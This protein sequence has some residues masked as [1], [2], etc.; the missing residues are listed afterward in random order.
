MTHP[1]QEWIDRLIE[2]ARTETPLALRDEPLPAEALREFFWLEDPPRSMVITHTRIIGDLDLT[3]VAYAHPLQLDSC[4]IEGSVIL[5]AATF[6]GISLT[7]THLRGLSFGGAKIDGDARFAGLEATGPVEGIGAHISGDLYLT[8]ATLASNDA[9]MAALCLDGATI[10]GAFQAPNL[11]TDGEFRAVGIRIRGQLVLS[12][13]QLQNAGGTALGLDGAEIDFGLFANDRFR[14]TGLVRAVGARIGRWVSFDE[15]NVVNDGDDALLLDRSTIAGAL[16][17]NGATLT[18]PG[19]DALSIQNAEINGGINLAEGFK[20]VGEIRASGIHIRGPLN[21]QG[22]TLNNPGAVA[23]ALEGAVITLGIFGREGFTVIGQIEAPALQVNGQIDLT[24]GT[25]TNPDGYA[26]RLDGAKIEGDFFARGGFSAVGEV[27]AEGIRVSGRVIFA[28][29]TLTNRG[30]AV[31]LNSAQIQ[32]L[33]VGPLSFNGM[34]D[35]TRCAL[36]ELEVIADPPGPLIA[37]GWKL[38]DLRGPLHNNWRAADRWLATAPPAVESV[39]PWHALADVYE[40]NGNPHGGRKLRFMAANRLTSQ[41]PPLSKAYG[42]IYRILVGHGYYPLQAA[43]WLALILIATAV[44]IASNRD[45][46]VP[47]NLTEYTAA[48]QEH[49]GQTRT[50]PPTASPSAAV[51]C[52]LYPK[53]PC[54]N[55]VNL[56]LTNLLPTAGAASSSADWA[57]RSDTW[58]TTTLLASKLIAW[59]LTALLLAGVTGLLRKT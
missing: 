41:S 37:T 30:Y 24:G 40:R 47:T 29:A 53:Y 11:T 10:D 51:P 9:Q 45:K 49:A 25:L 38:G 54:M 39:Q 22:A 20:A 13:A 14:A 17:L 32:H 21:L 23:L 6:S 36:D 26:L 56:T 55:A 16:D 5:A 50:A 28:G 2:S 4:F 18:N 12:G 8:D 31:S 3:H 46:I 59:A 33:I 15:A 44:V 57:A 58:L 1:H 52:G 7:H 19:G 42:Y 48:V 43:A 34:F 27:S 35:L